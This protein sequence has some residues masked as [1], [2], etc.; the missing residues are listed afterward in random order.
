MQAKKWAHLSAPKRLQRW[1]A[2][3]K[4]TQQEASSRVGIDLAKY[5]ALERARQRPSIDIAAAI[6]RATNGF[7]L[8]TQWAQPRGADSRRA[9]AA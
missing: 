7:V 3:A 8:A 2:A 1:R 4:L 5:N 9:H 6:E